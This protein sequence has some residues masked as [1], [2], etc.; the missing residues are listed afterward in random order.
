MPKRVVPV[1]VRPW[2]PETRSLVTR[3][4]EAGEDQRIRF[5]LIPRPAL[6]SAMR[7][8][9]ALRLPAP[10]VVEEI[11]VVKPERK[12]LSQ[13]IL[14]KALAMASVVDKQAIQV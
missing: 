14:R 10:T 13:D 11:L 7:S 1:R 3:F 6:I 2:A 5:R 4:R 12:Q 9:D 8:F